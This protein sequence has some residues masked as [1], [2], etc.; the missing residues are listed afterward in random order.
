MKRKLTPDQEAARD[1]RRA[2]FKALWKQVAAMPQCERELMAIKCGMR[3][4]DGHALSPSNVYLVLLQCPGATVLGDFRQWRKHGRTVKKG[5]HGAM[6]W[7]PCGVKKSDAAGQ[8]VTI[9]EREPA[10]DN[11]SRFITGT[12]FDISQTDELVPGQMFTP[13]PA[14][15]QESPA[16][17]FVPEMP[18]ITAATE[19]TTEEADL[20]TEEAPPATAAA[21]A[22]E[23]QPGFLF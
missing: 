21:A 4:C 17:A 19:K 7:V 2:K 14:E 3:T 18:P 6:I 22:A 15:E 8:P 11:D 13:E 20:T 23:A 10:E 9:T 1:A 12:I 5:E 16:S